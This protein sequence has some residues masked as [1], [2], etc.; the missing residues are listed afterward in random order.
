MPVVAAFMLS[1]AVALSYRFGLREPAMDL[2]IPPLIVFL[3][4]SMLTVAIVELAFA[5]VVSGAT[6]L[7]AG[8]AQLILLAFAKPVG[9]VEQS[10]AR[11]QVKYL[12]VVG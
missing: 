11:V 8:F 1:A 12:S 9:A 7:V 10:S 3:P 2:L 4:G 6:R 5:N